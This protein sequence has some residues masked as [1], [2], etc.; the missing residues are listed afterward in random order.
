MLEFIGDPAL[1]PLIPHTTL[2]PFMNEVTHKNNDIDLAPKTAEN[3]EHS[4]KNEAETS[5]TPQALNEA[6][7]ETEA[8]GEN[9]VQSA[10]DELP[11]NLSILEKGSTRYYILGTAHVSEQSR[12]DVRR[13]IEKIR[14]DQ[15]CIELDEGRYRSLTD[16]KHWEKLDVFQVIR[17]G[18]TLYLLA[19]LAIS[20]YQ[21]RMGAQLGV[22][23]GAE[24]LNAVT[25]AQEVGA[26]IVLIDRDIHTTLKRS[27]ANLG[28]FKKMGLMGA[29]LDGLIFSDKS[30]KEEEKLTAEEIEKLKE[31]AT[32]SQMMDEFAK[33][34]PDVYVPLIAERDQ[35]LVSKMKEAQGENVVAVVGAGHVP[36]MKENFDKEIDLA[37]LEVIPPPSKVWTAIKWLFPVLLLASFVYGFHTKG[38]EGLENLLTAWIL[39][40]S[41]FC[42][43]ACLLVR[44]KPLSI[45]AA[46]FVSP[47]TSLTP[48]IGAGVVIGL[49]EAWLRK[50]TVEDCERIAEDAHNLKGFFRNPVTRT[51]IVAFAA[52]IGSATGA[53]VGIGWI[54]A[55]I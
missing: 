54:L 1:P 6:I 48:I 21:R 8:L 7:L 20:A 16:K 37:P 22:K 46:F 10:E 13:L 25:V 2:M 34:L 41:I 27:W 31:Q 47:I 51:L 52:T 32:L 42:T 50:P 5:N 18:K 30:K 38:S 39:P 9:G 15:V 33:E 4:A 24:L 40:N 49:L 26:E 28:F 3:T 17:S 19:N 55:I 11:A 36:G 29:I 23:P 14:P 35:Y 44:A 45:L 43:L 12:Q 53:W